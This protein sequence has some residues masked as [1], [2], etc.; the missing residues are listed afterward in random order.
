MRPGVEDSVFVDFETIT[1]A[2][3]TLKKMTT[4]EY[5]TDPR[6]DVLCVAIARG[7]EDVRV[8]YKDA[9]E[10]AGL[11]RARSVLVEAS[12]EGCRFVAHNVGFD[13]LICKLLWGVS[14]GSYFDTTGYAR[15]LGIQAGLANT[16][17]FFGK[18]KLEAPPFNE[19]SLSDR[20]ALQ[21]LARYCATDTALARFIFNQAV[22]DEMYPD[23]EF[24]VNGMTAQ[25]NLRGLSVDIE[26][27]A[28]LAAELAEL[29]A[30]ALDEFASTFQFD[31]TDLTKV[32]KV[33]RFLDD[34]W[35][36]KLSSLDKRDP[37]RADAVVHVPEA[38][39][40]LALRQRI[41]TLHK[42]TQNVAAYA[43]IPRRVY[44]FLHYHGAHTGRFTA[45]GR[46][47]GKLNIHTL[48]KTKNSAKIT[49]LGR[50]R[51]LI[52]PEEGSSFRAADLSNIE[53]R[54]VAFLA[55]EHAL[56]D[57]FAAPGSDVYIWF[58]QPI[59]PDV[60]IVKG[61][62]NDHLR[63]LGKE[64]VLGL[65]FGMGFNTFLDRVRTAVPGV[66]IDLV[67]KMFNAYQ[68]SFPKIRAIRYALHRQFAAVAEQRVAFPE[69]PC[70][71]YFTS[72]PASA[73][74]SVV[75]TLPTGRS[76]FYRSI[77]GEDELGPYGPK[78]AYWYAPAATCHP[79]VRA[80]ARGAGQKRFADGQVR[81]RITP[82]VLVENVVQAVARDLMVH[83][84]LQL[85]QEGLRVA[86]HAHDEIVVAC[87]KCSCLEAT[88]RL[89][90][91]GCAWSA[92]GLAMKRIMSA[93]PPTLPGLSGLPVACEVKEDVRVSYAG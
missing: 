56:L 78:R 25:G 70:P 59:F 48:F 60:T 7:R 42:A 87:N 76:L 30:T 49:E 90:K 16:A 91:D 13:G 4:H 86:F 23:A 89:H 32:K 41:H 37:G 12:K 62:E 83:Q 5:V 71:M 92:A 29:R 88:N 80:R 1:T 2:D 46:D 82:Q 72:E 20:K 77:V 57:Q 84:A 50:E 47:A 81:S 68:G 19:A 22:A 40:F 64:A 10:A 58:A 55:G 61:G 36:I 85:E 45:G 67:Q 69:V 43:R 28:A 79:S 11:A 73:G 24:A 21:R 26:R 52:V 44:N 17:A 54:I 51:T 65:G 53:A 6:F 34:K 39:R 31:T 38:Q 9:P 18:K 75:V 3:L 8:Y 63:Q 14:F 35:G 33:L 66:S 27:A 93:V 15:F 74:P